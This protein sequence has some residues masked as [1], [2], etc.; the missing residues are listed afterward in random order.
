MKYSI[1]IPVYNAEKYLKKCIDSILDQNYKNYELILVNDGSSDSSGSIC[2]KYK[3]SVVK[4]IHKEN[5]GSTSARKAGSSIA[6]G[7]Y[8]VFIDADDFI[9]QDFLERINQ[10]IDE[11]DNPSIMI[12]GF[13]NVNSLGEIIGEPYHPLVPCGL[14]SDDNI[15]EL[16][17]TLLYDATLGSTNYGRLPF[18]LWTKAIKRELY[19]SVVD[20]LDD[21]VFYGEDL[22]T[23]KSIISNPL[24]KKIGISYYSGYCYRENPNSL[25]NNKFNFEKIARYEYTI[26]ALEKIFWDEPIKVYSY[27]FNALIGLLNSAYQSAGKYSCFVKLA[28]DTLKYGILWADASKFSYRCGNLTDRLKLYVIKHRMFLIIY[29]YFK[30]FCNK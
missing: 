30:L 15:G 1:I 28:K 20:T 16:E 22:I 10:Y 6:K 24:C 29:Y 11:Y 18:S 21:N 13:K 8:I 12:W 9:E 4:V 25:I 19:L 23:T 2:N 26:S 17:K 27:A 14:Y 7:E 5:G 3:D